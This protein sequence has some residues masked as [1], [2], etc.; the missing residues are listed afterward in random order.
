MLPFYF[1]NLQKPVAF[2]FNMLYNIIKDKYYK[3]LGGRGMKNKT[4]TVWCY[5]DDKKHC[6]VVQW[7]LAANVDIQE[8]KKRLKEIKQLMKLQKI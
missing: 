8:A 3:N 4:K 5:L 1:K 7:A 6:D 2:C